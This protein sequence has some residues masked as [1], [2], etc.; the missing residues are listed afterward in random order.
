[1]LLATDTLTHTVLVVNFYKRES[2]KM[3]IKTL[4]KRSSELAL[5]SIR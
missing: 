4:Q 3:T 1:M 5:A 2:Y